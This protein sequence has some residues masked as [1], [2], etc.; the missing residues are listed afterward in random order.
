MTL[1]REALAIFAKKLNTTEHP[2]IKTIQ[3]NMANTAKF[4]S[5]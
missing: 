2:Y 4:C 1:Y 3:K 5:K